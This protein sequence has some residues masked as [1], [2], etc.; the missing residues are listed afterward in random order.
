ML[1]RLLF[2]GEV[3]FVLEPAVLAARLIPVVKG[4]AESEGLFWSQD[5]WGSEIGC[6]TV[7]CVAGHAAKLLGYEPLGGSD[8]SYVSLGGKELFEVEDV[9]REGLGLSFD[10][11]SHLF[12]PDRTEVEA[13]EVLER[14][15]AGGDFL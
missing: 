10:N 15:A 4:E 2:K 3:V 14:I 1:Y 12:S 7:A 8:W 5:V 11:A 9:A 6:G 13:V